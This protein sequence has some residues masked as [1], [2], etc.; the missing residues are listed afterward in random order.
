MLR[1]KRF[2]NILKFSSQTF[3]LWKKYLLEI[4]NT[5]TNN[6]IS[7]EVVKVLQYKA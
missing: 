3:V 7:V 2:K 1:S 6:I 4:F 5:P